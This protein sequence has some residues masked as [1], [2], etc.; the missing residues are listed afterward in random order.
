MLDITLKELKNQELKN[1]EKT[2]FDIESRLRGTS[3]IKS[4]NVFATAYLA[5]LVAD[6]KLQN[7]KELSNYVETEL[8]FEQSLF[9]K[10]CIGNLW[11]VAIEIAHDYTVES[12]LATILWM[13]ISNRRSEINSETPE[14][15]VNLATRILNIDNE[16]VAD[17]CCGVGNFLINAVEQDNNSKYYGIEINTHYKEIS[18]IRLN[19]V[20]DYAEIEQG[21]V[22]DLNINKKFDKIFCDYPWNILKHNTGINKESNKIGL[23]IHYEC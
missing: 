7:T 11:T 23:V 12:L 13:P 21:T 4:K 10:E 6:N 16:K 18:D 15:I 19:L 5:Y 22:F 17:F 8:S 9:L 1:V 14:S 20:S 3:E 2:C